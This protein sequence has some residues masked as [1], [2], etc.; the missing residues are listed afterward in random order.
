MV[1]AAGDGADLDAAGMTS[2]V[3]W[4]DVMVVLPVEGCL[5]AYAHQCTDTQTGLHGHAA[6]SAQTHIVQTAQETV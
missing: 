5:C 2:A 4:C 6:H 1:G 3:S